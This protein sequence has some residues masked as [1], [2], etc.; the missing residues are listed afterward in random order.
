MRDVIEAEQ[1]ASLGD[2]CEI[3]NQNNESVK[4]EVIAVSDNNCLLMP[5]QTDSGLAPGLIVYGTQ[6]KLRVPVGSQLI[7]RVLNGLG[8]TIDQWAA[9][10]HRRWKETTTNVPESLGRQRI[11]QPLPTGIRAI[12]GLLTVGQGQRIGLFAGSGVGKSTLLG[13]IAKSASA[14]V[15]VIALI[16]ERG[17]EVRPFIEETLG[18]KGMNRSIVVVATSDESPLMKVQ[19]V[20]TAITIAEDLRD[21]GQNVLF[22]FDS[23][24]RFAHAQKEIG[25]IRG[26]T[27]GLRGY[28]PS[29]QTT[30]ASLL[31]RLGNNEVGSITGLITVLVDADDMNDPVADAARSIL[32]G[33]IVL[34][35]KLAARN[36]YPAIDILRSQSRLFREVTSSEQQA[37]ASEI[38][39]LLATFEDVAEMIQV[40]LYQRGTTAD[41][42]QAIDQLP[43]INRFL[44][45][46]VGEQSSFAE[47]SR[48]LSKLN[49]VGVGST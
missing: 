33:H 49:E 42:D 23:L 15:N 36:H 38:R 24:T 32:D 3:R 9:P 13:E 29:V 14:D 43:K 45:Q 20:K 31:E 25:L 8:Q 39:H 16:G 22:F 41:I 34:D 30:M 37:A 17:R 28:P 11:R 47:T 12:D 5:Y 10:I 35:R 6:Q 44:Q 27:P 48:R 19:A 4:A 26:E 2:V 40:G 46:A 18:A 1:T 7:G 21:T